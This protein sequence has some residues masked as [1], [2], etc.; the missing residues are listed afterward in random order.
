MK[1][2]A[3]ASVQVETPCIKSTMDKTTSSLLDMLFCISLWDNIVTMKVQ[4]KTMVTTAITPV[5]MTIL[6]YNDVADGIFLV[7]S[8]G[9]LSDSDM[10]AISR[11]V[12][13]RM[14]VLSFSCLTALISYF[15]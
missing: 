5:K 11:L 3:P 7:H 6:R 12:L 14:P 9:N 8:I 13:V 1:K 10:F 4:L 15:D 2:F